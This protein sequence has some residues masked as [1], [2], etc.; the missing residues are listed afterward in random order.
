MQSLIAYKK[1][2]RS[3]AETDLQFLENDLRRYTGLFRSNHSEIIKEKMVSLEMEKQNLENR[4]L[5]ID[6]GEA[7]F[8]LSQEIKD[9]SSTFREKSK[10]ANQ[11][12]S[13]LLLDETDRKKNMEKTLKKE[14]DI[15]R[16]LRRDCT[17]HYYRFKKLCEI[18]PNFMREKLEF[19]P[20][21]KGYIWNGCWFFGVLPWEKYKHWEVTSKDPND[22]FKPIVML[23]KKYHNKNLFIHE[24][25]RWEHKLYE[26][27]QNGNK[28]LISTKTRKNHGMKQVFTAFT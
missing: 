22:Y 4:L 19:M 9:Q 6:S 17:R 25:D 12:R 7:D 14:K 10:Q 13:T 28:V 20:S 27:Q 21:N 2:V 15:D 3:K 8:E 26:K 16:E 23:E 1:E 24:I 5:K 18:F 11:K